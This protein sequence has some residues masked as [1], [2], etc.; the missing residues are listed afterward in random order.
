MGLGVFW[1]Y[2][3][4]VAPEAAPMALPRRGRR[5][6]DRDHDRRP[7]RRP[8][9]RAHRRLPEPGPVRLPG[10]RTAADLRAP[11]RRLAERRAGSAGFRVAG[12]GGDGG[13]GDPVPGLDRH[14]QRAASQ[15][16][17][18]PS[19]PHA[20]SSPSACSTSSPSPCACSCFVESRT[21]PRLFMMLSFLLLLVG[22]V[23]LGLNYATEADDQRAPAARALARLGALLRPRRAARPTGHGRQPELA[24]ARCG[25]WSSTRPVLIAFAVGFS[26][27][28]VGRRPADPR[29]A[30]PRR[31]RHPRRRQPR[32][33]LRR[34]RSPDPDAADEPPHAGA[35]ASGGSAWCSTSWPRAW[36][37][38]PPTARSAASAPA[39]PTCSA[40]DRRSSWGA[41]SSS[42][43]TPP[44]CPVCGAAFAAAVAGEG[45]APIM[46]RVLKTDGTYAPVEAEAGSYIEETAMSGLVISIR[47]LT[48]RLRQEAL[49]REAE[50]RFRVAF[51]EAPIG[52]A[53][54]T[55]DGN[56]IE[57]NAAFGSMLGFPPE[58]LEDRHLS[59]L[60]PPSELGRPPRGPRPPGRR[61]GRDHAPPPLPLPARQRRAGA[62]RHQHLGGRAPGRPPLPHRP[63]AGRDAGERHRR[64]PRLLGPPRRADRACSTAPPSWSAWRSAL[65]RRS[66]EET[67]GVIFLDVDRFKLI[68]DSLGHAAGDRV[69]KTVGQRIQRRG[70]RRRRRGPLRRRRVR[71]VRH[72]PDG[73]LEDRRRWPT[74]WPRTSSPSRSR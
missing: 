45:G 73:R 25:R 16:R 59:E 60:S 13:A 72:R 55:T 30:R 71:R 40:G 22:D 3:A 48:V 61:T 33:H 28:R 21:A 58:R 7:P 38:P 56:L 10:H 63:G 53:L 23:L 52:M 66:A 27:D 67:V 29:G 36:R 6:L 54:A 68:N 9:R 57:V 41:R 18:E 46:L 64:A 12:R 14:R 31:H 24:A 69:V 51:E 37:S 42:S 39:S 17:R 70:R 50:Q 34:E 35:R 65:I 44:T 2:R 43:S 74:R 19:R 32:R 49:L 5:G 1:C 4:A 8:R 20:C 26:E 62:G 15:R 11:A 47:D